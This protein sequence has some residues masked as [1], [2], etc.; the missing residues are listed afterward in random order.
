ME[1]LTLERSA[2]VQ[3]EP[4]LVYFHGSRGQCGKVT[5]TYG[6][7]LHFNKL[8]REGA[9]SL[10]RKNETRIEILI[11]GSPAGEVGLVTQVLKHTGPTRKV[12]DA[13]VQAIL[14]AATSVQLELEE[15]DKVGVEK[16]EKD[17]KLVRSLIV[18]GEEDESNK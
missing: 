14:G 18:E 4:V 16:A 11:K 2:P 9:E 3:G 13:E 5:L 17:Q 1:K 8:L 15:E 6:E 10:K 7:W 12:S